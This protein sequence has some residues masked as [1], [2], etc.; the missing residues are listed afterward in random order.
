MALT[1]AQKDAL[2]SNATHVGRTRQAIR[3]YAKYIRDIGGSATQ[4]Q[5]DWATAVFEGQRVGIIA[6]NIQG[7]LVADAKFAN[8]AQADGSDV[9]DTNF[10]AA[11]EAVCLKYL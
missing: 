10:K 9:T 8:S 2:A 4:Q 3:E 7:E 11:V 1:L 6:E 5:K